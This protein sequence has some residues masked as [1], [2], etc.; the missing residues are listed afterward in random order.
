MPAALAVK[1]A[2]RGGQLPLW[3]QLWPLAPVGRLRLS[4]TAHAE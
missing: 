2:V 4:L 1:L 3:L